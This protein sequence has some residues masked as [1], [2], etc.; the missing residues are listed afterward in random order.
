MPVWARWFVTFHLV[1]FG[2]ILF[3]SQSLDLFGQFM[4]QLVDPGPATLFSF[5]AVAA[6]VLVIQQPE[7]FAAKDAAV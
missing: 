6:V 2:W 1:V 7:L 3:R 4:K 5:T